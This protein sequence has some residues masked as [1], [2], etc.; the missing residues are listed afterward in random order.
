[1]LNKD[2]FVDFG[3]AHVPADALNLVCVGLCVGI[4]ILN[5]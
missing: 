2:Y 4:L 3:S 1:M 5:F